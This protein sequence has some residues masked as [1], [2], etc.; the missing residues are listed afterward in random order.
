LLDNVS[1]TSE[2]SNAVAAEIRSMVRDRGVSQI[3]IVDFISGGSA[4]DGITP[5]IKVRVE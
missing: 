3:R 5:V 2:P 1:L 4:K